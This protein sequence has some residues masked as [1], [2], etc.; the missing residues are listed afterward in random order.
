MACGPKTT[1]SEPIALETTNTYV[2]E[3]E[4]DNQLL[5]ETKK[6]AL[7]DKEGFKD[8]GYFTYTTYT[9][10]NTGQLVRIKN[11][12]TIDATTTENYYFNDDVLVLIKISETNQ[13]NKFIYTNGNKIRTAPGVSAVEKTLYL[14]KA[15]RFKKAFK[16]SKK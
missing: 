1:A 4:S 2:S 12:E 8:I 5:K 9:D 6:G 3:V 13:T 14:N 15:K 16:K 10:E 7:T 11:V